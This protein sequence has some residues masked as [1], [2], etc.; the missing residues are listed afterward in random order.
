MVVEEDAHG[1][2]EDAKADP[3]KVVSHARLRVAVHV[4]VG[5]G[6]EWDLDQH[7]DQHPSLHD[8][9]RHRDQKLV[10]HR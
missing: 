1:L 9:R 6:D 8:V 2:A 10:R 3:E 7:G 5:E 4:P